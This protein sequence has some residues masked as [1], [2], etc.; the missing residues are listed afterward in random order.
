MSTHA[1]TLRQLKDADQDF[2][3]YPTTD[4]MIDAI[5]WESGNVGSVL[6]IGA[7]DG[8]V[9]E[10]IDKLTRL[11]AAQKEN[12][13][14]YHGSI[15]KYAIEKAPIHIERMPPDI[16]IVGTDF[17]LQT[18]IDKKVDM[19]FCN[20]P[21]TEY[22]GWA[23]KIIKE[24]NAKFVFLILP[25]RWIGSK[26]I[27]EAIKQRGARS[28]S[29]WSGDFSNADR[30]ARAR[31]EII[32][33]TI[34]TTDNN[35]QREETKPFNVWFDEYF[36]GFGKLKPVDEAEDEDET[37]K[38]N[39]MHEIV[40][41][42]NLIERLASLYI[43]DMNNL[44]NNYKGLSELDS[45]L[46][47]EIGVSV[48]EIKAALKLKI[49]GLKNKYWQELFDK[50]DKITS[51][52]TRTSREH[53]LYKLRASCNVDFS[54]DN[55]Y[56]IILWAI[57]NVN[58]YIDEQLITLFKELSEPECVKNYVSNQ[59]TWEKDRWRYKREDSHTHYMLEYRI[60]THRHQAI[61][62]NDNYFGSFRNGLAVD[63]HSFINDIFTIA[64]NL[65]FSNIANSYHREWESNSQEHFRAG[66]GDDEKILVAV[67][68]FKNGNLHLKFDQ[69]FIKTLNVEASRLLGWIKT[70]QDAVDEM[71]LSM[72]FVKAHFKTNLL[73]VA[74]DGQRLLT[75]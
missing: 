6:D 9:L 42:Q 25:D 73:F 33:I 38:P 74:A 28:K 14:D 53:L 48:D 7:G 1:E 44:L 4:E 60:I 65:G 23:T 59:R 3:W 67:R 27:E 24:A 30:Q 17:V 57:K 50:L 72:D 52:L 2:E 34:T 35:Y 39:P 12:K 47:K 61:K 64:N 54:V 22:E 16:S 49:E 70:P 45:I 75:A 15:D 41:G 68:A 51:R 46:L 31:V 43:H 71:G 36:A 55:A 40:E 13:Y 69:K 21:Y 62:Q 58:Q 32:K 66:R 37:E 20:P 18:L 5:F 29:I 56:A 63:C 10:R 26:L 8:R 19:V 11:R